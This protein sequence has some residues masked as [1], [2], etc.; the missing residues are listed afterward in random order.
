[1][2]SA[3]VQIDQWGIQKYAQV[4]NRYQVMVVSDGLPPEVLNK[5]WATPMPNLSAALDA[6]LARH[7]RDAKINILSEGPYVLPVTV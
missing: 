1:M 7:G 4:L 6:A 5:F 3:P 2:N